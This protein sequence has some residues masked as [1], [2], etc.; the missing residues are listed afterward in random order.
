[1]KKIITVFLINIFLITLFASTTSAPTTFSLQGS[2]G[3][4]TELSVNLI[5]DV[6]PFNIEGN[7]VTYHSDYNNTIIGLRIGQFSLVSNDN[8]LQ[9]KITHDFLTNISSDEDKADYFL[10]LIT[11]YNTQTFSYC[12]SNTDAGNINCSGSQINLTSA[13][14]TQN[15]QGV[16]NISNNS[17]YLT[18]NESVAELAALQEG[19]YE[20]NLYF[21]LTTV[22]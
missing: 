3:S 1:M 7:E 10:Y 12:P 2:V 19:T 20:S 22:D 14:F 4:A 13:D 6:L 9:L 15:A 8:N 18:M 5:Q 16:Y 21:Y 17:I 11:N